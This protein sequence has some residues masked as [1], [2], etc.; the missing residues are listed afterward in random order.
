MNCINFPV[1]LADALI[2]D[3]YFIIINLIPFNFDGYLKIKLHFA[4][5]Y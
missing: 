3:V 4:E 1:N 5:K 2:I